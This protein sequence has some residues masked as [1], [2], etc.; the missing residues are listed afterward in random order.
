MLKILVL[1]LL[2]TISVNSRADV[3]LSEKFH[4]DAL[5]GDLNYSIYLPPGYGNDP[6]HR[7]PVVYLLHGVG[8]NEKVWP[9]AGHV[10]ATADALIAAGDIPEM[11]I[12][13]PAGKVSW[14]VDSADVGG[15]GQYATAIRDDLVK[16]IDSNYPTIA[17]RRGRAIAGNSMGGFGALRLALERPDV[18]V[19]TA[20]LSSAL[21]T[22][23]TEDSVLDARREKIFRGSFGKP[24]DAARFISLGPNA[25]IDNLKRSPEKPG[26]YLY[27]G[28]DDYFGVFNSTTKL[29]DDLWEAGIPAE[30]R[31]GDG[32]HNWKYWSSILPNVLKHFARD[33]GY[34][35]DSEA[36]N[37]SASVTSESAADITAYPKTQSVTPIPE[38][39]PGKVSMIGSTTPLMTRIVPDD[40]ADIADAVASLPDQ[41]GTIY[42]RTRADCYPVNR[43]IHITRS[44][45]ALIGEQG[46]TLCL[47]DFVRQPVVLIGSDEPYVPESEHIANIRISG[48]IIDGNRDNQGN[49]PEAES[50]LGKPY[51][52]NNDLSIH[53]ARDVYLNSLILKNARS[54]GL[55]ISQQSHSIFITNTKFEHNYFDGIAIDGGH[56]VFLNNFTAA[57]N[58]ASGVS[59]DTGSS[60]LKISDGLIR[61]NGHNGI[62]IRQSRESSFSDLSIKDNCHHG[63]FASHAVDNDVL[64]PNSGVSAITF[65]DIDLIR[66]GMAGFFY[67]SRREDPYLSTNNVISNTRIGG[68]IDGAIIGNADGVSELSKSFVTLTEFQQK[69]PVNNP[70]CN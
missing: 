37:N 70:L 26:I 56:A 33:F 48:L 59:V 27:A 2:L 44:N 67:G 55:V 30:L 15:P 11:F 60:N 12:V 52:N 50:A 64:V 29:Y 42:I 53:G 54:G 3:R 62:F 6:D 28:D 66:N 22:Q 7:Y 47:A 17:D 20:G 61:Y 8:D 25:Y 58:G 36:A 14:F 38:T 46:A 23:L 5:S 68:N 1:T 35:A 39:T 57:Y 63:V 51:L 9:N 34:R 10:A 19:S 41:G 16:Y 24:F 69:G 45:T 49:E 13:M 40:F 32:G 65:N 31:I 43:S 18:Y 4:S 21:W